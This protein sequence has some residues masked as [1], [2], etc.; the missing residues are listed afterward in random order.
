MQGDDENANKNVWIL[1][2]YSCLGLSPEWGSALSMAKPRRHSIEASNAEQQ[3][4]Q[5][6]QRELY[7]AVREYNKLFSIKIGYDGGSACFWKKYLPQCYACRSAGN[8]SADL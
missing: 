3:P 5:D 1:C 8:P 7:A 6:G 2:S 4:V